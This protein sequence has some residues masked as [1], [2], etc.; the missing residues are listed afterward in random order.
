MSPSPNS[1]AEYTTPVSNLSHLHKQQR[2]Q[3][4]VQDTP[5]QRGRKTRH[6]LGRDNRHGENRPTRIYPREM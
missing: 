5:Q 3:L 4:K 2:D 6:E 1:G